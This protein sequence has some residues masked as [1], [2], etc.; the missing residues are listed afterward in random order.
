M[1][2][3]MPTIFHRITKLNNLIKTIEANDSFI[4]IKIPLSKITD[5]VLSVID[6]FETF[7][8]VTMLNTK[9]MTKII[10]S[11]NSTVTRPDLKS[12]VNGKY[13][14]YFET[15]KKNLLTSKMFFLSKNF[16]VNSE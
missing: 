8:V 14:Q 16:M 9:L 10:Q 15:R 12:T 6:N 11:V 2:T 5:F 13:P 1:L 4:K 7:N 3:K